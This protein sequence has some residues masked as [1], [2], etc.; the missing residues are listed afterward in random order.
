M[1]YSQTVPLNHQFGFKKR[2]FE[3]DPRIANENILLVD[4]H[5]SQ[6]Y[7]KN[8]KENP[9]FILVPKRSNVS[10]IID[11]GHED[12]LLL[13]EEINSVSQFLK[14]FYRPTKINVANLGNIVTQLHVHIIA[15]FETDR[16][17]PRAIWGTPTTQFFDQVEIENIRSNF[18][19]YVL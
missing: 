1:E 6:V 13:M 11:L 16:A 4:L 17:W 18:I 5:L 3:V 2:M 12:Q 19:D 10:E 9:W 15:R 8:D 14:E 7:F